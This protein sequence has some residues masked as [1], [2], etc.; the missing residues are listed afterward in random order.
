[1]N[2]NRLFGKLRILLVGEQLHLIIRREHDQYNWS[3]GSLDVK[4]EE[5]NRTI[6]TVWYR[7]IVER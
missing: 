4:D 3:K 6:S 2:I 5:E 1:M 7:L